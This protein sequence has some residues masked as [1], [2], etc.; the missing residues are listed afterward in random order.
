MLLSSRCGNPYS[1]SSWSLYCSSSGYVRSYRIVRCSLRDHPIEGTTT[2][3]TL[4]TRTMLTPTLFPGLLLRPS[5][6]SKQTL[7]KQPKHHP[8]ALLRFASSLLRCIPSRFARPRQLDPAP[9]RL[10]SDVYLGPVSVRHRIS[11][12]MA[13]HPESFLWGLLRGDL[14]H[15]KRFGEFGDCGEPVYYRLWTAEVFGDSHQFLAGFQWVS[16]VVAKSGRVG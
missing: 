4:A 3:K 5:R 7:P 11:G 12:G 15:W 9:L 6:H 14:H 13:V 16:R 1:L 8:R 2:S 10:Q